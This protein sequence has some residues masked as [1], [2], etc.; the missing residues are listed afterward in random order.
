MYRS[1]ITFLFHNDR[2]L[3]QRFRR[4]S[5]PSLRLLYLNKIIRAHLLLMR[6]DVCV[7]AQ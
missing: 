5:F 6:F 1:Q 3:G 4:S 2:V 7:C